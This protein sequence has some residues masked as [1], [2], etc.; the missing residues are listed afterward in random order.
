MP[1]LSVEWYF[2]K[3]NAA[4]DLGDYDPIAVLWVKSNFL[5]HPS[6]S[7]E[8]CFVEKTYSAFWDHLIEQLSCTFPDFTCALELLKEIQEVSNQPSICGC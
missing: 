4:R 5:I 8:G 6:C 2:M 1:G 3:L 7:P